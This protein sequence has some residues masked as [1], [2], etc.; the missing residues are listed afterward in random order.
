MNLKEMREKCGMSQ[1]N[2]A[3]NSGVNIRTIQSYEQGLKDINKAQVR[4]VQSLSKALGCAI[5]DLIE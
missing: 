5:E 1:S 4:I 2:L 3:D